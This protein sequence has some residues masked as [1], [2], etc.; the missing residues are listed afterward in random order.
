[1]TKIIGNTATTPMAVPDMAQTDK[2]KADFVKNKKM[3]FLENDAGYVT[4]Q[5]VEGVIVGG[6]GEAIEEIIKIQEAYI[7]E[8]EMLF[9]NSEEV[10]PVKLKAGI[11]WAEAIETEELKAMN[12]GF[13]LGD[14][15]YVRCWLSCFIKEADYEGDVSVSTFPTWCIK[16]TDKVK[17]GQMYETSGIYES[18]V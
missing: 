14:D 12:M 6:I 17:D 18:D 2:R 5:Y 1:M 16:G 9:R 11:T 3:S 13:T 10:F 7:G 15:G 4:E 8:V